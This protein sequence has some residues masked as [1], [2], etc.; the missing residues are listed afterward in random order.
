VFKSGGSQFW[1]GALAAGEKE[2]YWRKGFVA[3]TVA[4]SPAMNKHASVVY[5]DVVTP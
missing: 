5:Y 2:G 1:N 4:R 3:I